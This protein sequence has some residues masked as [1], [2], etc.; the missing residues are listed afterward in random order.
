MSPSTRQVASPV[1]SQTSTPAWDSDTFAQHNDCVVIL[2]PYG[3]DGTL[4]ARTLT[5]ITETLLVSDLSHF[6]R[7]LTHCAVGILTT[8]ALNAQGIEWLNETLAHQPLWSDI[9]LIVLSNRLDAAATARLSEALGNVTIIERPLQASSL[10]TIVKTA[11]RAR[12]KQYQ[13]RDLLTAEE[14]QTEQIKA[15]NSRLQ[16]A[17]TETH[18]RVKNS[19]QLISAFVEM[20]ALEYEAAVPLPELRRINTHIK[21]L[22]SVHE[23]LTNETKRN[24]FATHVSAKDLLDHLF[25][26]LQT[27]VGETHLSFEIED[28]RLPSRQG[29]SLALIANELILNALKHSAGQGQEVSVTL[30]VEGPKAI[31][32]VA[33]DGPGFPQD[34]N[35]NAANTGLDLINNLVQWDLQGTVRYENRGTGETDTGAQVIVE[36]NPG[37]WNVGNEPTMRPI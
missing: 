17:M 20:Q 37:Q 5:P 36:F 29:T 9:P 30:R 24:Q 7:L 15:L 21:T 12:E 32:T 2:A 25:P 22:A 3:Q 18:H 26:M 23:V 35:G 16:R 10:Q 33:D 6:N 13:V 8:D 19:L 31:L 11:L 1:S 14:K 34:F 4:I 27:M 28:I